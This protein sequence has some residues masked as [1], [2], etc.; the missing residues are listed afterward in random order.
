M[1]EITHIRLGRISEIVWV[2]ILANLLIQTPLQGT[3]HKGVL[4]I[5]GLLYFLYG[6]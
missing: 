3:V 5:E 6:S 2:T 4:I 1:Y